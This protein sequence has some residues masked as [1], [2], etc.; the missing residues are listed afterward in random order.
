MSRACDAILEHVM[1]F[2]RYS[3]VYYGVS[4]KIGEWDDD[5]FNESKK[6][7]NLNGFDAWALW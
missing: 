4:F 6:V 7:I 5:Y 2:R 1:P 3:I